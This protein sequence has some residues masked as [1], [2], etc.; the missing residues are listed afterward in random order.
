[1]TPIWSFTQTMH[2]RPEKRASCFCMDVSR[3]PARPKYIEIGSC[4]RNTFNLGNVHFHL[5]KTTS[6]SENNHFCT[7]RIQFLPEI[8][9]KVQ[10]YL[11]KLRIF[12]LV[13]NFRHI[14]TLFCSQ[15]ARRRAERRESESLYR[16][17]AL[18]LWRP[19]RRRRPSR[20]PRETILEVS[21]IWDIGELQVMAHVSHAITWDFDLTLAD[22]RFW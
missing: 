18:G 13:M 19:G 5:R 7:G 22:F 10:K 11:G 6:S 20:H 3:R 15:H 4:L 1:M 8:H 17:S 12:A 16:F 21:Q 9:E 14:L 2:Q